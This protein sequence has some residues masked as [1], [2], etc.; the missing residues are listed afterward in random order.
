MASIRPSGH[1]GMTASYS[2]ASAASRVKKA[3]STKGESV[4]RIN[5][6]SSLICGKDE[7]SPSMTDLGPSL[8]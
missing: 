1:M 4:G 6:S 7:I 8:S 3:G 5:T 2:V